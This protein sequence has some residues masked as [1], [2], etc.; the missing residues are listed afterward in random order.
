MTKTVIE[1]VEG[2]KE[3]VVVGSDGI[4][5]VCGLFDSELMFTAE[6]AID[7]MEV[8]YDRW[9]QIWLFVD[10]HIENRRSR[11]PDW[12]RDDMALAV[13]NN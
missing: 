5:T 9:K 13:W 8:A 2:T 12:N 3:K 1:R 6:T 10:D 4:S 11:I 7:I